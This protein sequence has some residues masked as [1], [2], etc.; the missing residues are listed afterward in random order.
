MLIIIF[1]KI[2]KKN[3]NPFYDKWEIILIKTIYSKLL[4]G[5]KFCFTDF[6]NFLL[7]F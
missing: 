3:N 2:N 6:N 1:L 7:Y 5:N 4:Q